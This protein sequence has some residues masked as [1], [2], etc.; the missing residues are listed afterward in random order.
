MTSTRTSGS[1]GAS[2]FNGTYRDDLPARA[3]YSEAA[4]IGR[5]MPQAVAVPDDADDVVA[6]VRWAN[7]TSTPLVPRGSG[8]SMPGGAIGR[9]VI[10][11]VSRLD[12]IGAPDPVTRRIVVGTGAIRN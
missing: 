6:L 11:D 5:V 2:G 4:G 8:S 7:A 3:V 1:L 12:A 9:G 10:V